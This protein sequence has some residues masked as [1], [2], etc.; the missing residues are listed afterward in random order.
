MREVEFYHAEKGKLACDLCPQHCKLR[1]GQSGV[2]RVRQRVGK[3]LVAANYAEVASMALDPIEKKPLYH[4]HP[5]S[6]ILSVGAN[7]C[8]L[9]CLFCQNAEIS[10]G[11]VPTRHLPVGELVKMA[12][13]QGSIGVAFTYSEPLMWYE[14]ILDTAPE[15]RRNGHAVVLV[16]NGYIEE[17]PLLRLLPHVDA[18]N[19]DLKSPKDEFYVKMCKARLEPV[20]RSIRL[21][22]KAGVHV[23]IAH[24]V[25][26]GWNDNE[27][28][29][30]ATAQWIASVNP[31]LPLHLSRY[32]PHY[33][34]E[35]PSTSESFLRRAWDIASRE[36]NYVYLGNIAVP[37]SSDTICPECGTIL[38]E[39]ASYRTR[40]VGLEGDLCSRC[41][42]KIPI[43]RPSNSQ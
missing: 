6:V 21:A 5:G 27:A 10:Q 13:T 26:T 22:W 34:S 36:L 35:A 3:K 37:G 12:G 17:E 1:D 43:K 15:L 25:V 38:V 11:Q 16:T 4:F 24:L 33:R 20:Q 7:G 40:I 29:V 42:R 8:N 2:C 14:Y 18:M 23:E 41:G 32:F 30:Q 31:D 28:S 39:R 19:V 9:R